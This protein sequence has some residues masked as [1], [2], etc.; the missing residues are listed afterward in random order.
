MLSVIPPMVMKA[1]IKLRP[2][3][4]SLARQG[5]MGT[6]RQQKPRPGEGEGILVRDFTFA[7]QVGQIGTKWDT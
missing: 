3:E 1:M 4:T 5:M 2:L 6:Y 7:L